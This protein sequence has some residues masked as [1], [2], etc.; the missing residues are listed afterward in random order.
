MD[1]VRGWHKDPT[2][3]FTVAVLTLPAVLEL[4]HN[5]NPTAK[6][7]IES[8]LRYLTWPMLWLSF[9]FCYAVLHVT[10]SGPCVEL[11]ER[12]RR[13]AFWFLCNGVWY[14]LF[15]DVV[16][17][18]LSVPPVC[19]LSGSRDPR[20]TPFSQ[21]P[22]DG[23]VRFPSMLAQ[24]TRRSQLTPARDERK[25]MSR[26]Y[27]NVEPRY[28]HGYL[29]LRGHS[30]FW[31]SMCEI[32]FQSPFCLLCFYAY[33]RNKSWRRPLEIIVSVLQVAGVWWFY[34]PEAVRFRSAPLQRTRE[35][36]RLTPRPGQRLPVHLRRM[37]P[38][39]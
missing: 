24:T 3:L 11:N 30:V 34:V 29:D 23:R 31:T 6:S 27:L 9:A 4:A 8:A 32:F 1:L 37:A 14:N 28:A 22:N 21:Q 12:D 35:R 2:A 13:I 19:F 38:Q 7:G 16:S 17:G 18:Q 15:L 36:T 39:Q 5:T 26:Q 20:L 33:H 10:A 25:S